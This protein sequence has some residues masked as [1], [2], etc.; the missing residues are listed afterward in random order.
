M[1]RNDFLLSQPNAVL[2]AAEVRDGKLL[3][4]P[5]RG[6]N[7]TMVHVTPETIEKEKRA[8]NQPIRFMPIRKPKQADD[9]PTESWLTIGRMSDAHIMINDYT[10]SK[11]HARI[12]QDPDTGVFQLEEL[13][14]T[15]GTWQ[16]GKPVHTTDAVTLK[17]GDT[18]RFGR[19]IFT[20]L[21]ARQFYGFLRE[22][23]E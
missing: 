2:I 9:Q 3:P 4:P 19:H 5:I 21:S 8:S 16:N 10:I 13:G 17:S 12:Q 15:N 1:E 14:S 23:D 18:L 6:Q 20:F 22:L 7:M 11:R